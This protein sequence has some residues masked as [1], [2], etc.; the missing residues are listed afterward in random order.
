MRTCRGRE[1]KRA[2]VRVE[3][4]PPPPSRPQGAPQEVGGEVAQLGRLTGLSSLKPATLSPP[5]ARGS[6]GLEMYLE[7]Q[8]RSL[9]RQCPWDLPGAR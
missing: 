5:F 3:Q 8:P 6:P 7:C 1:G 9:T 2:R 4:R